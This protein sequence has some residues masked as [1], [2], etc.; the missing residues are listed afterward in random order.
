MA[1]EVKFRGRDGEGNWIY[2]IPVHTH[3]GDYIVYEENPHVC[4]MYGYM[5]IDEFDKVD[6]ETI[7]Q[8]TGLCDK[9]GKEIYEGDIIRHTRGQK[10]VDGKM[11]DAYNDF[12][13]FFQRGRFNIHYLCS[14]EIEVIGN[15]HDNIIKKKKSK[16]NGMTLD[17]I[18]MDEMVEMPIHGLDHLRGNINISLDE[19]SAE[20]VLRGMEML[21][22]QLVSEIHFKDVPPPSMQDML[23][24]VRD[25]KNYIKPRLR[26][27]LET[28]VIE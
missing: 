28:R 13:V 22:K 18:A 3:I 16:V 24:T 15:I 17:K 14:A 21:E 2:G 11:V 12:K 1:R 19:M 20:A 25:I 26:R 10:Q 5:E 7:G 23:K 4:S 27:T 9:N 8:F 6:S